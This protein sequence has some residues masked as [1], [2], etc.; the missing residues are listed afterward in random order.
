MFLSIAKQG[1]AISAKD[2]WFGPAKSRYQFATL[3]SL[4][5]NPTNDA[6]EV[7]QMKSSHR[8]AKRLDRNRDGKIQV[9]DF[10][11]SD[12]HP[13][14]EASY[15]TNRFFRRI[16]GNGDGQVS[17][18]EWNQYYAK[19]VG[20]Q[21]LMDFQN[22]RDTLLAGFGGGFVTGDS[23]TVEQLLRGLADGDIGSLH[24]GPAIDQT[25]P[26]F[27]LPRV[28]STE[29]ITLSSH[30]G[31]R[32]TVLVFG[33]YTC[34]PFRSMYP[35]VETV[36]QR[37]REDA[38]FLFVYVREAHPCNGW[39]MISNDKAGVRVEQPT[40]DAARQ[41]IAQTC[42]TLLKPTIPVVVDQIDDRVGHLYSAM[43]A[44]LYVLDREGKVAYQSGR[45]PF[46][47]KV[48]E[49]E[50]ALLMTLLNQ[51]RSDQQ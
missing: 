35:G 1:I 25:A 17:P 11:W 10:D 45:G 33:N 30:F 2:G 47:F 7:E 21:E 29:T 51:S 36:A 44:R 14:V 18:A 37:F 48:D 8:H 38:N 6:Y 27:T 32:P 23:P 49:M 9:D 31:E 4:W 20:E 28:G 39:C 50:Q 46:G 5:G 16:D 40:D 19:V 26:D 12:K 15:L 41:Q 22:F 24:E 43:P 42:T 34:G 3:Q 13:W